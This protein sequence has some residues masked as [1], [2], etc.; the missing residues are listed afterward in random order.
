MRAYRFL[1]SVVTV[2]V[3]FREDGDRMPVSFRTESAARWLRLD[4]P[5]EDSFTLTRA[6]TGILNGLWHGERLRFLSVTLSEFSA[7]D[8]QLVFGRPAFDAKKRV[9]AAVDMIRDRYGDEAIMLGSMFGAGDHAPERIGFRKTD[10]LR[11]FSHERSAG[12]T[13]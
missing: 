11:E 2:A 6:A 5:A 12:G 7:P 13:D 9:S 3:S 8:G 1:A 4:E 10:M